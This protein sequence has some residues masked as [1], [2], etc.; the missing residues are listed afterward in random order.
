MFVSLPYHERLVRT[1]LFYDVVGFQTQ[2]WLESFLHYCENEL[3][4]EVDKASGTVTFEGR[5][6]IAELILSAS[7]GNISRSLV[8]MVR[9]G[10][11]NSG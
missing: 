6:T 2:E 11:R 5:T 8:R 9:R 1:L 7:T 3:R 10:R 4:A